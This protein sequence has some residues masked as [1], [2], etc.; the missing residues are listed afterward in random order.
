MLMGAQRLFMSLQSGITPGSGGGPHEIL[1][2]KLRSAVCRANTLP[3]VRTF[4][5]AQLCYFNAIH[6]T[7]KAW[8]LSLS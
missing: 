4:T 2:I 3:A 8:H 1:E 6:M 7:Q 5:S